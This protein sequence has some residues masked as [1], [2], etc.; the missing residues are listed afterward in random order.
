MSKPMAAPKREDGAFAIMF[1]PVL[2]VIVGFCGLAIDVG[3]LYNRT[4]DLNGLAKAVALAAAQELNGTAAGVA[5]AKTRARETAERL[6][7]QYF[8]NGVSFTWSDDALSFSTSPSR[9][10]TWTPA[11]SLSAT[12]TTEAAG[13]YFARVDTSGLD[14]T[15]SAVDT[16]FMKLLSTSFT[17]LHLHDS[18]VAG[19]IS[20][21]VTPIAVCAMSPDKAAVRTMAGPGSTTLSELIQYGFRRGVSY[22]LMQLNPNGVSPL[23]FAV[24]PAAGPGMTGAPFDSTTLAPFLCSGTMWVPRLTGG[25]IRVSP[26]PTTS[27]LAS[28]SLPLNSRFN[29]YTGGPCESPF[30]PPDANVKEYAYNLAAGVSWMNP[31]SGPG[32]GRAA[33]LTTTA[34]GKLETVADL[35]DNYPTPP[36]L[37][38]DYGPLWAY[39]RAAKAPTPPDIEPSG[40]YT[41]F[42]AS[43]WAS[44]YKSGPS[45]LGIYP[46]A[47]NLP[48]QSSSTV[49]G[50]FLAPTVATGTVAVRNRRVLSIPLLSCSPSAPSGA[51]APATVLGFG[52]FF[53]TVPA[54]DDT[55]IAEFAGLAA[56]QSLSGEVKLFP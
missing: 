14:Q 3:M 45:A 26:L 56:E 19:K 9:S 47:P 6:R 41:P 4:V 21:N 46:A 32:T 54:T 51:N 53:M 38:G 49:N 52:R 44:L 23:R 30:A 16:I 35:P 39:T 29:K 20:I 43:A 27:P 28:L 11:T 33:A 22:D 18:A 34:R 5:T 15:I 55:M 37:K 36:A 12:S 31:A 8:R 40:G 48:Y 2:I 24:N 42:D 7:Y 25:D 50:F 1:A 17:T 13:L 10:G